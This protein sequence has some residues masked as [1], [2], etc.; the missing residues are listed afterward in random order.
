M[1]KQI[2]A[3]TAVDGSEH[4][5]WHTDLEGKYWTG[6]LYHRS[7]VQLFQECLNTIT[8]LLQN[9]PELQEGLKREVR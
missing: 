9:H 4:I 8:D 1:S 6:Y 7:P 5:L 3:G 2:H